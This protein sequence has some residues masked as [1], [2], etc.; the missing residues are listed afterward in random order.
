[1]PSP[2]APPYSV[3]IDQDL[4]KQFVEHGA[5]LLLLDVPQGTHIGLDQQARSAM[6]APT[7][8]TTPSKQRFV[9]GDRFQGFKMVPPGTHYVHYCAMN[10]ASEPTYAA[11]VSFFISLGAQQ[12]C[13]LC[14]LRQPHLVSVEQLPHPGGCLSLGCS[15]GAAFA[16]GRRRGGLVSTAIVF[17]YTY[18][19]L[20]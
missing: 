10:N 4:A 5:T 2:P 17:A 9:V 12:V 20:P 19:K 3:N 11:V 13:T 15:T 14:T 1:M 6:H 16:I 7:R 8:T 18:Y